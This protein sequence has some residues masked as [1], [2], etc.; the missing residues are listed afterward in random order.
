MNFFKNLLITEKV[1]TEY[2]I[3]RNWSNYKKPSYWALLF[4]WAIEL[5]SFWPYFYNN[6]RAKIQRKYG[7][8]AQFWPVL[9]LW[10]S[11]KSSTNCLEPMD[12]E[13]L[14]ILDD[15]CWLWLDLCL[16]LLLWN[17]GKVAL[18]FWLAK[19]EWSGTDGV[20]SSSAML[21]LIVP[22]TVTTWCAQSTVRNKKDEN[23]TENA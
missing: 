17:N 3:M 4:Y 23:K 5:L 8:I 15:P 7:E 6:L 10:W 1:K 12:P 2:L 22:S 16:F 19:F 20:C 21:R 11:G 9:L 13:C 18:V 14:C